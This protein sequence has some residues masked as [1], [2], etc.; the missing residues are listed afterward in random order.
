[1]NEMPT[2][3]SKTISEI[4][5]EIEVRQGEIS[6]LNQC[7][8]SLKELFA[9]DEPAQ[10][11]KARPAKSQP[12]KQAADSSETTSPNLTADKTAKADGFARPPS[13]DTVKLMSIMRS[14]PEPFTTKSLCVASGFAV[15]FVSNTTQRFKAR[16]WLNSEGHD[17]KR[18]PTFPAAAP[19]QV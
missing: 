17:M 15:Q 10:P 11:V 9:G 6:Q 7:L 3:V 13:A 2:Y 4:T 16:G 18:T 12:R 5:A 1:M 19:E 14:A 8:S